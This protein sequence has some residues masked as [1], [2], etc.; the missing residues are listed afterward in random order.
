MLPFMGNT[1]SNIKSILNVGRNNGFI[2][3]VF[4][5]KF[6]VKT[7]ALCDDF[8]YPRPTLKTFTKATIQSLVFQKFR[9]KL[10]L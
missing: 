10:K 7:F 2:L 3:K 1:L 9:S 6:T 8:C 4:R 5:C